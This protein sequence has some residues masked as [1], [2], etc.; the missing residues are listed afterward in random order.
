LRFENRAKARDDSAEFD[1]ELRVTQA[2]SAF[3]GFDADVSF[4][5]SAITFVP[6]SPTSLQ[7]GS[8][9]TSA[10]GNTFHR[11]TASAG[12]P[13]SPTSRPRPSPTSV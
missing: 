6:L 5:P 4:D 12:T 8:L 10:C 11:F 1:L 3:N 13:P 9:M 2:G 7:Q